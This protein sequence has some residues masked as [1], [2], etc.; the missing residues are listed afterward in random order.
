MIV[1]LLMA[2]VS[3]NKVDFLRGEPYFLRRDQD[4]SADVS[5][6]TIM[7]LPRSRVTFYWSRTSTAGVLSYTRSQRHRRRVRLRLARRG[8]I[9]PQTE[10]PD[11][12]AS[13][14]PCQINVAVTPS[15]GPPLP[16]FH[17]NRV[18]RARRT[19][20]WRPVILLLLF[21]FSL[22]RRTIPLLLPFSYK[23]AIFTRDKTGKEKKNNTMFTGLTSRANRT[24][25]DFRMLIF[26]FLF[27]FVIICSV[28][29]RRIPMPNPVS[30]NKKHCDSG[31]VQN[32]FKQ[33]NQ[34][35]KEFLPRTFAGR[36]N[37]EVRQ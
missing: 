34:P 22:A 25:T 35:P 18:K 3:A 1:L 14:L 31:G 12:P 36:T 7:S 21:V 26:S 29:S 17:S 33:I 16:E 8:L 9:A 37:Y 4:F 5:T 20:R 23:R 10:S 13:P 11:S 15:P 27:I 19:S 30:L 24:T 6:I 32:K 28:T 2:I